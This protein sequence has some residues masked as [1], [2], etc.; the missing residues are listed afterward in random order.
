MTKDVNEMAFSVVQAATSG[1]IKEPRTAAR[2]DMSGI[3][4]AAS[5]GKTTARAPRAAAKTS[6]K[7]KK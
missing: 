6:P 7:P 1:E 5:T 2:V 4:C 3:R